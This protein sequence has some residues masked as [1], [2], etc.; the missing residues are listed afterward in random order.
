MKTKTENYSIM[1]KHT[2]YNPYTKVT[3][4]QKSRLVNFLFENI[5]GE[6]VSKEQ[7]SK[8]VEYAVKDSA[9]FGGFILAAFEAE[10]IQGAIIVNKTGMEGFNPKN[11][12]T[13]FAVSEKYR[14][15]GI[16]SKL[17]NKAIE[18]SGGDLALHVSPSNNSI[19]LYEQFGF[20]T[21]YLEMRLPRQ[22][23]QTS[24]A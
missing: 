4:Y 2:L 11:L 3:P 23:P 24:A 22:Q 13:H 19:S 18:F 7:I 15:N 16:A 8:A 14:N 5:E 20:Q 10:K 17:M 12:L 6:Q 1:I 21:Q 9:S